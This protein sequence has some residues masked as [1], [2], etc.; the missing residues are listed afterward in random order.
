M[1]KI[2]YMIRQKAVK[3]IIE[4]HADEKRMRE[5]EAN[6]IQEARKQGVTPEGWEVAD[7]TIVLKSIGGSSGNIQVEEKVK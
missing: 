5:E 1:A 4:R 3:Q 6:A 7:Q 2:A